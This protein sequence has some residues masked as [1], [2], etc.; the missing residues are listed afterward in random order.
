MAKNKQPKADR[1]PL[2]KFLAWKS[3]DITSAGVFLI[4]TTYMTMFCT[5]HLGMAP[6]VVGNIILISNVIDFFT[7]LL[8]AYVID[9]TKST[10]SATEAALGDAAANNT[11]AILILQQASKIALRQVS[12]NLR[13]CLGELVAIWA[14][15]LC[16]YSPAERLLP[17][18]EGEVLQAVPLDYALLRHTLLSANVEIGE[19]VRE[20]MAADLGPELVA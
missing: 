10:M 11:S 2:G 18:M 4:V 16:A 17:V 14:D 1:L 20:L 5:D 15:M 7:D 8:A 6:L 3:S 13:R 12:A 9:N 19:Q